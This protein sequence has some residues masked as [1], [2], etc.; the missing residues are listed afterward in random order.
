[1]STVVAGGV[2]PGG[3]VRGKTQQAEV[4]ALGYNAAVKQKLVCN[5]CS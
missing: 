3:P 1:M 4:T 5:L 2:D